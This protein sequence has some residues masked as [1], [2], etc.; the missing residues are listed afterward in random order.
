MGTALPGYWQHRIDDLSDNLKWASA[1]GNDPALIALFMHWR[2]MYNTSA[3]QYR[4]ALRA[5]F[6]DVFW[7][8]FLVSEISLVTAEEQFS[9]D[10]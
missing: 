9:L 2:A 1:T 3:E 7:Q 8:V 6:L 5:A 4:P 10:D